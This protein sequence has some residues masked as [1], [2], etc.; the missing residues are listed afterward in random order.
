MW[1]NN[2][3]CLR[4]KHVNGY[5]W[6]IFKDTEKAC[7]VS[8]CMQ[9]TPIPVSLTLLK[10]AYASLILGQNWKSLQLK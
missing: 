8:Y 7:K 1:D 3:Y 4:F 2:N 9:T 5:L 6:V 10:C